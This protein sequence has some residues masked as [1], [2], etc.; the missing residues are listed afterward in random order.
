MRL[1]VELDGEVFEVCDL[2]D[3]DLDKAF[4]ASCVMDHIKTEVERL[5]RHVITK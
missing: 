1:Y 4:A 3:Y 5:R 2:D